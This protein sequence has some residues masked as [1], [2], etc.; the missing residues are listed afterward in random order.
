MGPRTPRSAGLRGTGSPP[1]R[2]VA[3]GSATAQASRPAR[4]P[5]TRHRPAVPRP[6]PHRNGRSPRNPHP[7]RGRRPRRR[8]RTSPPRTGPAGGSCDRPSAA[9]R[10]TRGTRVSAPGR[11]GTG[12]PRHGDHSSQR[13]S[14]PAEGRAGRGSARSQAKHGGRTARTDRSQL[15]SGDPQA[16]PVACRRY[17]DGTNGWAPT[18]RPPPAEPHHGTGRT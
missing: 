11:N 14:N 10:R 13:R 16:G 8:F 6:P 9:R 4:S 18:R 17:W 7:A 15:P 3:S 2:R 1:A 12:P 5:R